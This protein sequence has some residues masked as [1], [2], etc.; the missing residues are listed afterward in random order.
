MD[1]LFK[2][3]EIAELFHMNIRTLRYYDDIDLLKPESV[4]EKTGYRYYSTAQFEQLNTIRYLR[5]LKVPLDKIREFL[6]YREI[7]GVKS[8]LRDQIKEVEAKQRELETVKRKISTRI[9]QIEYAQTSRLDE[10]E[11]RQL[12]ARKAVIIKYAMKPDSD[13]EYPIRLLEKGSEQAAVFLGKVGL[14]ISRSNIEKGRFSQYDHIFLLLDPEEKYNGD[15][16]TVKRGLYAVMRFNGTHKEAADNYRRII[17]FIKSSGYEPAGDSLE[18]TLIDYGFTN[19]TT[20][21]V[22]EIQIPVK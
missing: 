7:D 19:D 3:G 22:T 13:M 21:F 8:I 11:I 17:S 1:N 6:Q 2:I 16:I 14:S 4:D 9:E 10:A 15:T 20:Q 18:I 12:P 5:E